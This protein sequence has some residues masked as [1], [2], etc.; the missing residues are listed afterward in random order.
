MVFIILCD[1]HYGFSSLYRFLCKIEMKSPPWKCYFYNLLYKHDA[2]GDAPYQILIILICSY[3][4][5][6]RCGVFTLFD[7]KYPGQSHYH[8]HLSLRYFT[9]LKNTVLSIQ[10]DTHLTTVPLTYCPSVFRGVR[11]GGFP[12]QSTITQIR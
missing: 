5:Q 4:M 8:C 10:E 6:S 11:F 9:N 1:V 7:V 3:R 2:A 12:K